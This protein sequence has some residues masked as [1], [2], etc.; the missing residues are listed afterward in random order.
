MAFQ[1]R[2][3]KT[4]AKAVVDALVDRLD[5]ETGATQA[6]VQIY[7]GSQPSSPEIA[8][9]TQTKLAEIA[10]G[11]TAFGPANTTATANYAVATCSGVPHSDTSA[12]GHATK[13]AAWFRAVNQGGTAIIDGDI[14]TT[15]STADMAIDNTSISAGQTVKLTAWKVRL[16]HRV[17]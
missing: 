16:Q 3:G 11:T 12:T 7:D 1:T 10:I 5:T 13:T 4:A 8:I 15:T 9:G 2:L 17:T 6:L 14:G